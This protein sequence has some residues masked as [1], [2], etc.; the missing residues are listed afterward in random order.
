[1]ISPANGSWV[2]AVFWTPGWHV[3]S[4]LTSLVPGFLRFFPGMEALE[5]LS[6]LVPDA[7]IP[8]HVFTLAE[9]TV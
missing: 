5:S 3:L 2:P 4:Q 9:R 7:V 1:M 6:A 8:E